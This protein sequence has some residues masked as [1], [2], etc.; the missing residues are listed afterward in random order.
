MCV[1][2]VCVSAEKG[3]TRL[4]KSVLCIEQLKDIKFTPYALDE[5][6]IN[7]RKHNRL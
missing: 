4:I 2:Y 6:L 3:N 7:L 5:A 1:W